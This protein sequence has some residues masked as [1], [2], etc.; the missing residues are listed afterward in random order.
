M[1]F[2]CP[3]VLSS[4]RHPRV[5]DCSRG[6]SSFCV[7]SPVYI[8]ASFLFYKRVHPLTLFSPPRPSTSAE[9]HRSLAYTQLPADYVSSA[10]S[11]PLQVPRSINLQIPQR[12]RSSYNGW[13]RTWKATVGDRRYRRDRGEACCASGSLPQASTQPVSIPALPV[14][15][16]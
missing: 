3:S 13:P 7:I 11:V 12:S 4:S 2:V 1:Q 15:S 8:L 5:F 9:F 14:P 6:S 16:Q 10:V